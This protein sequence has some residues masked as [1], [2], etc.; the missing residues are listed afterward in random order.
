MLIVVL[1]CFT[2]KTN[3]SASLWLFE[4]QQIHVWIMAI[5]HV[6][7]FRLVVRAAGQRAKGRGE[8]GS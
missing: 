5:Y 1:G 2:G 8:V 7:L 3:V 4:M 6:G